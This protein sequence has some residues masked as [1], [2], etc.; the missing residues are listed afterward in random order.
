MSNIFKQKPNIS[1]PKAFVGL[2]GGVDS[3][4]SAALLQKEGYA[5]TGVFIRIVV[6]GYPCTAGQD[7]IDAMRVAAHLRVPFLEVD[8][9]ESYEKEVF[10][11][12]I[13]GFAEGETSNPDVL[14]NRQIKFGRF[15][16][17]CTSRGADFIATGHYA[18]KW[19]SDVHLYAGVDSEKDQSYFLW[20]VPEGVLRY[21]LFPV[22][23][24]KKAEVRT[25]AKKFGLPNAERPDS[26]GLCFLGPISMDEMLK[27]EL[28][29]TLGKVLSEEGEVIGAHDGAAR[30]TLGQRHG[31][32]LTTSSPDTPPH[33]VI[34]KDVKKNTITVSTSRTPYAVSKTKITLRDANWIGEAPHG[35]CTARFRYRQKL[36]PA[37]M[38]G[39]SVTLFEPRFVPLG[40]SLVLYRGARCLGGGIVESVTLQ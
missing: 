6:P 13:E 1:A 40:Q 14:C 17:F 10:R 20:S 27:R 5:V 26:Q 9:S 35:P 21:T 15:F 31:F 33:F 29:L 32:T 30:Y 16:E 7:R 12:S 23:G 25:L 19:P 18:Q 38:Q 2:S 22:G 8:F 36:I 34:G 39:S 11:P 4:V 28:K 24:K 3:A 37:E